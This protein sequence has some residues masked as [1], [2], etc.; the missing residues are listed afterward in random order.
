MISDFIGHSPFLEIIIFAALAAILTPT[1]HRLQ[2]WM[3]HHLTHKHPG[4]PAT[5]PHPGE[6]AHSEPVPVKAAH[7]KIPRTKPVKKQKR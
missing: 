1:H 2:N 7:P 4:D 5:A 6:T 3:L